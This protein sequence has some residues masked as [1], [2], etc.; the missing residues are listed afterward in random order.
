[1]CDEHWALVP[2]EMK[3][4]IAESWDDPELHYDETLD[5]AQTVYLLL[6]Q[7]HDA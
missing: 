6:S 4:R 7:M 5:A 2:R 3:H 1:M